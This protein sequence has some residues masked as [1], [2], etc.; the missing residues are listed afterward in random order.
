MRR[1]RWH[2]VNSCSLTSMMCRSF[3]LLSVPVSCTSFWRTSWVRQE[4]GYTRKKRERGIGEGYVPP[5]N[6]N[7]IKVLVT[8]AGSDLFVSEATAERLEEKSRLWDA[9]SWVPDVQCAWQIVV[10]CAGPRCHHLLR[11]GPPNQST[12]Y[13]TGHDEGMWRVV[14]RH[15]ARQTASLPMRLGGVGIHS[16]V[17]MAPA[18][19]WAS[20]TDALPM[21]S[22]RL[23]TLTAHILDE[24]DHP[25]NTGSCLSSLSAGGTKLAQRAPC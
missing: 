22:A 15:A 16:A 18:A 9:V 25:R 8:P 21:L 17:R 11:T 5:W 7:G 4:S 13:A 10:E 1:P 24:L 19:F 14:E 3:P 2:Q 6:P 12:E 20:W 23:P